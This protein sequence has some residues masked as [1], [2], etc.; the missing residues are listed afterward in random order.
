MIL[1]GGVGAAGLGFYSR[2]VA[3]NPPPLS[4]QLAPSQPYLG[5]GI[6]PRK[7]KI[8]VQTPEKEEEGEGEPWAQF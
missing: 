6:Y 4:R 7:G 1:A 5:E 2:S 3:Q 8:L